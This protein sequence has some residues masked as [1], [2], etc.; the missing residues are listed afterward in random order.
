MWLEAVT[1]PDP[2]DAGLADSLRRGHGPATPMRACFGF[3]LQR[4]VNH[5]FDSSRIVIWL[6]A[7]AWSNLPKRL[8]PASDEA[9]APETNRL[10][11]DAVLHGHGHLRCA[12]SN[13]KDDPAT[14]CYLLWSSQRHY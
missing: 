7:P 10:A 14:Q 4:G 9:L 11:V 8:K 6:P 1:A 13:R 2:V 5:V 3:S 12:I